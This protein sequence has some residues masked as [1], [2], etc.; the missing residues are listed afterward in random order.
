MGNPAPHRARKRFGQHFLHDQDVIERIV[1]AVDPRPGNCLIE[2]GP[3]RGALTLPL[4]QRVPELL[5]I[6]LDRDLVAMLER[7]ASGHGRLEIVNAD[8]LD[9]DLARLDRGGNYRLVGNLPYNISTPLMFHLLESADLIRDMHFMVQKEVALRAIATPGTSAYGRLSVMLQYRCRCSYLFGVDAASFT[10]RPRVESAVI[11]LEPHA[12]PEHE[13]GD[14]PLFSKLVQTAFGQRR[15][16]VSNSLKPLLDP[17]TI[18]ACGVDP[19]ARAENLS[20]A[21][22]ASLSRSLH[23]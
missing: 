17:D 23:S 7:Q 20:L 19:R 12:R 3:G 1:G 10:P 11:R 14:F 8:I 5:A 22:F 16:T 13:V 4:L 21:D 2:I 9:Y 18:R 15:K 6:E